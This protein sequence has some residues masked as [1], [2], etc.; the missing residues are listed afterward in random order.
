VA[1]AAE[2]YPIRVSQSRNAL[3]LIVGEGASTPCVVRANGVIAA[4]AIPKLRRVL[5]LVA[6][7]IDMSESPIKGRA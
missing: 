3:F 1:I 2:P 5:A 4:L 6:W 7:D